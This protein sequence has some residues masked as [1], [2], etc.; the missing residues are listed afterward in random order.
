MIE[1]SYRIVC[2]ETKLRM[3]ASTGFDKEVDN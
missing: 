1:M 3:I 2:D